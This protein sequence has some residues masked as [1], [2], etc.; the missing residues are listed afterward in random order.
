MLKLMALPPSAAEDLT[1]SP[2][3]RDLQRVMWVLRTL[4]A[5]VSSLRSLS[6]FAVTN[7]IQTLCLKVC[8]HINKDPSCCCG[9]P[10]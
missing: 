7:S 6:A 10:I 1:E 4:T 2:S 8:R 3:E 5:L 9:T